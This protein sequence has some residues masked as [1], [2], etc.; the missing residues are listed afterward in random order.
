MGGI[1]VVLLASSLASARSLN[2]MTMIDATHTYWIC[3][4]GSGAQDLRSVP[5]RLRLL[6]RGRSFPF[7]DLREDGMMMGVSRQYQRAYD[8]CLD[9]HVPA[10]H[11][12]L[13]IDQFF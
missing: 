11:L 7:A 9:D 6:F 8:L 12:L 10:D 3:L 13:R 1:S 2:L 4:A 5:D